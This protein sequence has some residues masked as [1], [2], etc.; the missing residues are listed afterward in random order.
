MKWYSINFLHIIILVL[1]I[2]L[3]ENFS[4]A[5]TEGTI[6]KILANKDS[7]DGKEVSVSGM[8]SKPKFRRRGIKTNILPYRSPMNLKALSMFLCGDTQR[9]KRFRKSK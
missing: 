1:A 7:F 4:C 8:V 5:A 3:C 9:S 2:V 6:E